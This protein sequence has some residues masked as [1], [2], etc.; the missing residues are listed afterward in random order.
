[1]AKKPPGSYD[2][3][4]KQWRVRLCVG[5]KRHRFMLDGEMPEEE[6]QQ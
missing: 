5:G 3:H 4:G 6:V 1:M 2:R